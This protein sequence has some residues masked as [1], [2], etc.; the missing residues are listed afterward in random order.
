MTT[1]TP[2]PTVGGTGASGPDSKE[3]QSWLS[4]GAI[5]GIAIGSAVAGMALVGIVVLFWCR[6]RK[7]QVAP[8][9]GEIQAAPPAVG[10]SYYDGK[11]PGWGGVMAEA[12]D[13]LH[14]IHEMPPPDRVY[15]MAGDHPE[16]IGWGLAR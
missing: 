8:Q 15:E 1:A 3:K 6:G 14:K 13:S 12:P 16:A 11:E 2:T 10:T 9:A 5:A 7:R 4:T